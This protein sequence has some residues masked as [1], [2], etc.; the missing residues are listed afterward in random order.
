MSSVTR[1]GPTTSA[2]LQ[3]ELERLRADNER[4]RGLLGLDHP[5]RPGP[6]ASWE[7]TLF[8]DPTSRAAL[9]TVDR[10]SPSEEKIALFRQLFAGRED[11]YAL[12][13]ALEAI[14]SNTRSI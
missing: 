5:S 1:D 6:V 12:R 3:R 2:E 10:S 11:V 13:G 8:Q 9:P 7:P 4:L 14:I